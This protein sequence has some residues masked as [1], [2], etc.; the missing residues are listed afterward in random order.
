MMITLFTKF[1]FLVS[2]VLAHLVTCDCNVENPK[3]GKFNCREDYD[4]S[5]VCNLQCNGGFSAYPKSSTSCSLS[6]WTTSPSDMICS[7]SVM[8]MVGSGYE[9]F[10][11]SVELLS[12][13]LVCPS[14]HLP[15]I[16]FWNFGHSLDYV[17]GR[18]IMCGSAWSTERKNLCYEM[19]DDYEWVEMQE[20]MIGEHSDPTSAVVGSELIIFTESSGQVLDLTASQ[21][22]EERFHLKEESSE[23]CAVTLSDG[24]VAVLGSWRRSLLSHHHDGAY[25][26][27]ANDGKAEKL[28]HM[29]TERKA[30]G[31]A[32]FMKDEKEF[33]IVTGGYLKPNSIIGENL[34]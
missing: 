15:S 19:T 3:N 30:P 31:C 34:M 25:L 21:G 12:I 14:Y 27:N 29:T 32:A 23:V 24:R 10:I 8:L 33:I 26:Y 5:V 4:G 9:Y 20:K 13:D 22:W 7:P 17:D 2:V 28:P 18:I 16:P 11:D 1:F 6:E